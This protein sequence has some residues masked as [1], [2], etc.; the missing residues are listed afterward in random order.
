MIRSLIASTLLL[1]LLCIACAPHRPQVVDRSEFERIR[2]TMSYSEVAAIIGDPGVAVSS[3]RV[4]DR[5][6]GAASIS[7][8]VYRWK[9]H[10]GSNMNALFYNDALAVKAEFGLR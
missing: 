10:D 2:G 9:N 1:L 6:G 7:V 5:K 8:S 3:S 4:S